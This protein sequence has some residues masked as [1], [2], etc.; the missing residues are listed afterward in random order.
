MKQERKPSLRFTVLPNPS[1]NQFTLVAHS[2]N[3]QPINIRVM[4]AVG[5]MVYEAKGN[6]EQSMRFGEKFA[7]GLYII[8][9]K[10]EDE[11]R[12]LKA[13]KVK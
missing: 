1:S 5:K 7:N 9:V 13:V 11:L 2:T 6:V 3:T 8:E 10:Q 12:I 4:D